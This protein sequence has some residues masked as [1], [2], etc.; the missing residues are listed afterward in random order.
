[1]N[2]DLVTRLRKR[3]EI[4]RQIATR[5]SVQEGK[6]DRISDLLEEAAAEIESLRETIKTCGLVMKAATLLVETKPKTAQEW[7]DG[8]T[9]EQAIA[10]VNS[11]TGG[12]KDLEPELWQET[13]IA[14]HTVGKEIESGYGTHCSN[15]VYQIGLHLYDLTYQDG[16]EKPINIQFKRVTE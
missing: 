12:W 4:R 11:I 9:K 8:L 2:E 14:C 1:M 7:A 15:F 3:A 5:K 10:F 6:A 13:I 16:Y